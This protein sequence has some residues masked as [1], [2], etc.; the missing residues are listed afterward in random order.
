MAVHAA[1]PV[2]RKTTDR[3][4]T[5]GNL[6]GSIRKRTGKAIGLFAKSETTPAPWRKLGPPSSGGFGGWSPEARTRL[7]A[8]TPVPNLPNCHELCLFLQDWANS[9]VVNFDHHR[10]VVPRIIVADMKGTAHATASPY[11]A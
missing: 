1:K 7:L 3:T 11:Q 4:V 8:S 2:L 10:A 9:P 6:W 5:V